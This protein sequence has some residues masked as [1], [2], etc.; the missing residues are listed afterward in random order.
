MER[1]IDTN[2]KAHYRRGI[3]IPAKTRSTY[4]QLHFNDIKLIISIERAFFVMDAEIGTIH[5]FKSLLLD[6]PSESLSLFGGKFP[7]KTCT[8]FIPLDHSNKYVI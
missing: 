4:I 3:L 2:I 5:I 6:R 8:Y 7:E 1:K